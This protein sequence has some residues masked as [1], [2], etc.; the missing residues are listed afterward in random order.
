MTPGYLQVGTVWL[1]LPHWLMLPLVRDDA[2]W[3]NG[4]AGAIP[5]AA[6]FVLAGMFLFWAVRRIFDSPAAAAA[7]T[8]LFALNPNVLYLQSTPMTEPA[9]WA[10]LMALLYFTV[11]GSPVG[12]GLAA[13]AATLVRYEGWF[14]LP[15]VAVYFLLTAGRRRAIVFAVLAGLGPL[16]WLGH[17]YYLSGHPLDFFNGPYSA[18]AI[19]GDKPYA[20]KGELAPVVALRPNRHATLRRAGAGVDRRGGYRGGTRQARLLGPCCCWPYRALSTSGACTLRVARPFTCR[21]C[22]LTPTT[23]RAMGWRLCRCWW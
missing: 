8:A 10:A 2:Y 15:F 9:F 14:L 17:N 5:S 6:C 22:R 20:G 13:C 7:A 4:M 3:R 11:R 19:Q 1:P 12:A 18:R 16:F 23:T 21:C